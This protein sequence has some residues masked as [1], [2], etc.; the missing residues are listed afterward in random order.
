MCVA[1]VKPIGKAIT[2]DQLRLCYQANQ[3]GA[4]FAYVNDDKQVAVEKGYFGAD[5]L[6]AAFRRVEAEYGEKSPFLIH[7][8]IATGSKVDASNCHPFVFK[9]GALI[10]NG[11]LFP[12]TDEKSDT[13]IWT[14]KVGPYL[15][16]KAALAN[17]ETLEKSF[18]QGNKVAV[19]YKDKTIV[20]FNEKHGIWENG[21][22]F[23]NSYWKSGRI[24]V[25]TASGNRAV[26]ASGLP[27]PSYAREDAIAHG[28][29]GFGHRRFY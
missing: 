11:Y 7:F 27:L 5:A 12:S 19:L 17:K 28:M 24:V 22:W 10:H 8:R 20:I 3:Q 1:I 9:H 26:H 6:I 29:M 13:N 25:P 18:G 16:K 4:G 2:D 21:V 14:E 15:T 23:S